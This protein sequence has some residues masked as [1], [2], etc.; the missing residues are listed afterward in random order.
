MLYRRIFLIFMIILALTTLSGQYVGSVEAEVNKDK[1]TIAVINFEPILNDKAATLKKI[2]DFTI[3]AAKEGS[4]IIVFPETAL[5]GW[6]GFPPEKASELAET[7]PGPATDAIQK[8]AAEYNVY[9]CFGLI[10]KKAGD[11]K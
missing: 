4:N 2:G 11:S 1:V 6:S 9:V 10:E 8:I 5:T 7:I 3:K